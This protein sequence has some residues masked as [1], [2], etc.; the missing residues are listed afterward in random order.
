[1][2][3]LVVWCNSGKQRHQSGGP[4]QSPGPQRFTGTGCINSG[5]PGPPASHPHYLQHHGSGTPTAGSLCPAG[6]QHLVC[7]GSGNYRGV[8]EFDVASAG[9]DSGGVFAGK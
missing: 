7:S 2:V 8:V 1:M 9:S 6:S 5:R 4:H 3:I